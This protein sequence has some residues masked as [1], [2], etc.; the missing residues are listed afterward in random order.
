M[1]TLDE[2]AAIAGSLPEV[3]VAERYGLGRSVVED[4]C[5]SLAGPTVTVR[6]TSDQ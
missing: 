4:A 2:V 5:R 6:V 3:T 1:V